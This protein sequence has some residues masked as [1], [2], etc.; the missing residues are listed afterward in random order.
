MAAFAVEE[1]EEKQMQTLK[2]DAV[3]HYYAEVERIK[4]IKEK[5]RGKK[6]KE[7]DKKKEEEK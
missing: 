2:D 1:K 4:E 3:A 6:E 7:N 5:I